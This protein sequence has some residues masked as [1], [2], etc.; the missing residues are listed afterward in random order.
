[1]KKN[2]LFLVL[3]AGILLFLFV[4]SAMWARKNELKSAAVDPKAESLVRGHSP[5][6]GSVDAKV[7][8]VE[9]LDPECEACRAMHPIM[10][11]LLAEYSGRVRLVIRYMPMHRNSRIAAAALE[12][13]REMGK[14]DEALDILFEKQ[15]IWGDHHQP[16]PALIPAYMKQIGLDEKR[17]DPFLLVPKFR[18]R[19]DIDEADGRDLGVRRTPT[20]FVNGKQLQNIG[21]DPIKAA[22]DEALTFK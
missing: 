4:G 6:K 21:Y 5:V 22:I 12:E 15:P 13:A 10:K 7:T 11:T 8:V 2:R 14:F 16:N 19:L 1:M 20:F 9:F 3:A 17:F 18:S